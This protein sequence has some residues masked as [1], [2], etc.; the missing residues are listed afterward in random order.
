MCKEKDG[1]LIGDDM[2]VI[3]RWGQYFAKL[4]NSNS[5]SSVSENTVYQGAEPYIETQTGD[6]MFEVMRALK[7]IKH[8]EKII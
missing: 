5:E 6:E 2:P 1:K 4:L 7:I 3:D 8:R